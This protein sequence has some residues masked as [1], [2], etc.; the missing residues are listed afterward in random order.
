MFEQRSWAEGE[1]EWKVKVR[2]VQKDPFGLTRLE[3]IAEE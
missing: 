1:N 3:R 2:N